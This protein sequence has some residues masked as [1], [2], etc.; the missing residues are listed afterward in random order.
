MRCGKRILVAYNLHSISCQVEYWS[1]LT[2]NEPFQKTRLFKTVISI[3]PVPFCG[4]LGIGLSINLGGSEIRQPFR[5]QILLLTTPNRSIRDHA[6]DPTNI[7][8]HTFRNGPFR[9][10]LLTT[11]LPQSWSF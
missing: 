10:E 2:P 3:P 4:N 5:L 1:Y 6:P 11:H 7:H 9:G 8:N